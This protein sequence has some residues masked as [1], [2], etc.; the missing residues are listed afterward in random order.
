MTGPAN[1]HACAVVLDGRGVLITGPSGSGKTRLALRL[2]DDR[3]RLGRFV[4]DDQVLLHRHEGRLRCKAPAAIGGLVEVR[5]FGPATI[6]ADGACAVDL[7]VRLAP[8]QTVPRIADP[9][10]RQEIIGCHVPVLD[11]PER[12]AEGAALAV[13]AWLFGTPF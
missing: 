9:D 8:P 6:A 2:A 1:F 13:K 5:G 3:H 7:L 11:L 10:A 4:A 12:D